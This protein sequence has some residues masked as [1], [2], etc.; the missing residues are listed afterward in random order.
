MAEGGGAEQET[1]QTREGVGGFFQWFGGKSQRN[2][3]GNPQGLSTPTTRRR[4]YEIRLFIRSS[5]HSPVRLSAGGSQ[6]F[7][8]ARGLTRSERL[9]V[10]QDTVLRVC[11]S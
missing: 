7:P 10:K 11:V 6:V 5:V 4:M 9:C 3:R 8:R 1:A 2:P